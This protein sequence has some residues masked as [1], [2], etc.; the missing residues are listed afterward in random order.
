[1]TAAV[2]VGQQQSGIYFAAGIKNRVSHIDGDYLLVIFFITDSHIDIRL[3]KQ[4]INKKTIADRNFFQ[5][6]EIS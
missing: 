5:P 3:G 6:A 1:M 4:R 2:K